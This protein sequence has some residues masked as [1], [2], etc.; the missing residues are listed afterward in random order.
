MFYDGI[1]LREILG[2]V[3]KKP[4]KYDF[5]GIRGFGFG[6]IRRAMTPKFEENKRLSYFTDGSTRSLMFDE[7]DNQTEVI[8][9]VFGK[10]RRGSIFGQDL[11]NMFGN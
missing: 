10:E 3:N 2:I 1:S 9:D 4:A 7:E 6:A 8:G 5:S 11:G